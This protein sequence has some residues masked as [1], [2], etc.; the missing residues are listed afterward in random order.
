VSN[1]DL[2]NG[3]EFNPPC[4]WLAVLLR[5]VRGSDRQAVASTKDRTMHGVRRTLVSVAI[6]VGMTACNVVQNKEDMLAAAG[7]TLVPANTPERQASL[8]SLPPHKFVHQA[9]NNGVIFTYAD[10][11][12]CDCLYIG[13]Q[14]A[15]DRYRQEM[16]AKNLADEQ[17]MTAEIYQDNMDWG[18]WG[19]GWW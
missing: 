18:P 17:Q 3:E 4:P 14:A 6:C 7:F 15:Y 2:Y 13:N 11:T 9:R 10:P 8:K 16:F 12:I 1:S 19:P 5:T